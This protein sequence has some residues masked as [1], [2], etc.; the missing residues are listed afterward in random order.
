MSTPP[1]PLRRLETR[2]RALLQEQRRVVG[3]LLDGR[4][5]LRGSLLARRVRC[6]KAGCACARGQLHGPYYV[7]STRSGGEGGFA[8]LAPDQVAAARRLV[9]GYRTFRQ[10][11]RRLRKLNADLVALLQRYQRAA[12]RKKGRGVG[13]TAPV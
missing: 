7:L 6:G 10:G 4:Q 1:A 9:N 2:A 3:D 5:Q 12:A 11:V 13:L 8:Y